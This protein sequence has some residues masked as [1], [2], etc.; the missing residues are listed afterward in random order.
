M[1]RKEGQCCSKTTRSR[2]LREE[3]ILVQMFRSMTKRLGSINLFLATAMTMI[4][5]EID[6]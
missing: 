3:H 2:Q 6:D 1:L 5:V 4:S